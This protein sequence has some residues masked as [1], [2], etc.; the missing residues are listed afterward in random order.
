MHVPSEIAAH[1]VDEIGM[2]FLV[3]DK[4]VVL[5]QLAIANVWHTEASFLGYFYYN[6]INYSSCVLIITYCH[7]L[8][9]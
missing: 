5:L 4:V 1:E 9:T 3:T 7:I 8:L 6:G 2:F